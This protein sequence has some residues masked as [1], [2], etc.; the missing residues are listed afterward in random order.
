[1]INIS[2]YIRTVRYYVLF[3]KK[4]EKKNKKE[5]NNEGKINEYYRVT[6]PVTQNIC[7]IWS[8]K[9]SYYIRRKRKRDI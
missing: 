2:K 5:K 7:H 8:V 6:L 4:K 3:K 1:M 9:F